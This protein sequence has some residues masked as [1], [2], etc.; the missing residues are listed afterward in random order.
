[1]T[2]AVRGKKTSCLGGKHIL[3]IAFKKTRLSAIK[4]KENANNKP[5]RHLTIQLMCSKRSERT[6]Q[7]RFLAE[8]SHNVSVYLHT[9]L[10]KEL[11]HI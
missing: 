1:M 6:D 11:S 5:G 7:H 9:M 2:D 8:L 4:T 3:Y 10:K